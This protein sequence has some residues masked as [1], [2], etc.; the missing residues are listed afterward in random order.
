MADQV[1]FDHVNQQELGPQDRVE[2]MGLN[3][4]ACGKNLF[5]VTNSSKHGASYIA[6]MAFTG[7][8]NSPG[9]YENIVTAKYDTGGVGVVVKSRNY[10][11]GWPVIRSH[12]IYVTHLLWRTCLSTTC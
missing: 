9:H 2:A 1:F 3:E 8:L 10:N 7:W 6:S 4:F 12:D 11:F 5:M